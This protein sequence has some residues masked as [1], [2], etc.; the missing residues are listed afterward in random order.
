MQENGNIM[1]KCECYQA[2]SLQQVCGGGETAMKKDFPQGE[3]EE[4]LGRRWKWVTKTWSQKQ[5]C[6]G[7]GGKKA[8]Q[9]NA[10]G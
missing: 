9:P 7:K 2:K 5:S 8:E 4:Q 3:K 6:E 1:V 10:G